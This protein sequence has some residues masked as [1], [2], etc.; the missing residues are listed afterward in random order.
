MHFT[1]PGGEGVQTV[2]P[3]ACGSEFFE[4]TGSIYL[5]INSELKQSMEK[6][7][8]LIFCPR[9]LIIVTEDCLFFAGLFS[10]MYTLLIFSKVSLQIL[11]TEKLSFMQFIILTLSS[12]ASFF[13]QTAADWV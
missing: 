5:P 4:M 8:E 11:Q 9:A 10:G 3:S 12:R 7:R 13:K 1:S 2:D 6:N